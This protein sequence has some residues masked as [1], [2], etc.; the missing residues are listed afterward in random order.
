MEGKIVLEEAVGSPF[1]KAYQPYPNRPTV[2]GLSGLPFSSEFLSDVESRL[3]DVPA[4]L[5][6]MDQSGIKYAIVSLTSPGIE[7]ISDTA[8]A[9]SYAQK[10]ND[11]IYKTYVQAHPDRFGFFA[12][13]A[14]HDPEEAAKELER[15]VL[16][17]GAKGV[18]INGFTNLDNE[19]THLRYL[20]APECEPFWKMLHK[21]NVPLY[22]HP[23]LPP[24][25]QQVLYHDYPMLSSAS[26]GFGVQCAGHALRIMCSGILDR[27][28]VQIILGHCA[29]ALPFI[30]H[31][32]DQRM[33]I[34]N[35]GSNG[36]HT[37]SLMD[38]FQNHFYA[39][40]AG[41][42]RLSTLENTIAELGESR[43]MFSVDYP[44][45]SNEDAADWFD[46]LEM[47]SNTKLAIASGNAKRLFGL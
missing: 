25:H 13:V 7:G 38:Y 10:T 34:G 3:D 37:R 45:D 5:H 26:Y 46:E 22:L 18:L 11:A 20:D 27:Y 35:P 21:L 15:A 14:L 1:F 9:L 41:V 8:I 32:A 24:I 29:E 44:Y 23:R 17:L 30:I 19:D 40:L 36:A 39:T 2:K 28:P 16:H 4:R 33:A 12:C 31:R 43:V 6:S 47:S 42:R